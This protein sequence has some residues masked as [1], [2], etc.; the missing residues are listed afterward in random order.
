[1]NQNE[2]KFKYRVQFQIV[3]ISIILFVGKLIAYFLTNSIGI[4]TD[5]LESTVNVITGFVSLYS[6]FLALKPQDGDHPYGHGKVEL[7]SASLEGFLIAFAGLFII[8]EAVKR[9]FLPAEIHQ[10]DIGIIIVAVA[11]LVNYVVGLY[12]IRVGKKHHS[13]ALVSGGKHLLSD[14]YSSIGLVFGLLVLYFTKVAWLDSLVAFVFGFVIIYTGLRILKETVAGLMDQADMAQIEQ[15]GEILNQNRSSK[16]VDIHNLKIVKYGNTHHIDCD[17]TLPWYYTII[18]A[19]D[20]SER[21]QQIIEESYSNRVDL[22]I[23]TDAC[24]ERFCKNCQ[25]DNCQHR[26]HKFEELQMWNVS[27]L[28]S[29]SSLV[30][31]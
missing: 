23:H 21:L 4:L 28:I 17:L 15:I 20:E 22:T 5:A 24:S 25:I 12:S 9:L 3:T 13:I 1:M 30:L 19:H 8:F 18:E 7:L 16:W 31:K 10:L 6:I 29:R 27:Y 2:K 11:G 26:M 14:T